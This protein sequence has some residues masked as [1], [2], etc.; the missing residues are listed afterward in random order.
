M[1]N[2]QTSLLLYLY[3]LFLCY[4]NIFLNYRMRLKNLKSVTVLAF[5]STFVCTVAHKVK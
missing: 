5:S 2:T 3:C 1:N 4:H